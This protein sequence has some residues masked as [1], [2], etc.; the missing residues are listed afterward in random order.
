M[1]EDIFRRQLLQI[2]LMVGFVCFFAFR[3]H[4]IFT[5]Y[6]IFVIFNSIS[7]PHGRSTRLSTRDSRRLH[8]GKRKNTV[9]MIFFYCL[10]AVLFLHI[11]KFVK[12]LLFCSLV[13]SFFY[14]V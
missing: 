7:F 14:F 11:P 5:T 3:I 12:T 8:N 10:H 4:F 1:Q 2:W 6:T 9:R 13:R